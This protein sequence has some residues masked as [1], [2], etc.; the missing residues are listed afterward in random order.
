MTSSDVPLG[1]TTPPPADPVEPV[2]PVEPTEPVEPVKPVKPVEPVEPTE[3]A[4][5]PSIGQLVSRLTEQAAR[6]VRAEIDLAKTELK[7]RAQNAAVG[8]GL[9]VVAGVLSLYGLGWLLNSAALGLA[10]VVAP[11]LAALIVAVVLLLVTV[12]LALLGKQSLSRGLPPSPEH[13][14]ENIKLDVEAVK[15]GLRS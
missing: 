3:P 14:T 5:K 7:I 8:I 13:A 4:D 12:L 2:E 10:N 9:L 11:W 15:E 6:L 1:H